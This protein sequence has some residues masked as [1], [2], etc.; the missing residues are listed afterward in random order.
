[1]KQA[2]IRLEVQVLRRD[3][4]K[5]HMMES[6]VRGDEEEEGVK[7][8]QRPHPPFPPTAADEYWS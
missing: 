8:K 4:K 3:M 7:R 6:E 1:M 5:I 2:F